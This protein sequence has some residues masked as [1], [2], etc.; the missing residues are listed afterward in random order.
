MGYFL[1]E[2]HS[3]KSFKDEILENICLSQND[4]TV[5]IVYLDELKKRNYC[6]YVIKH[7][8]RY[9]KVPV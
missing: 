6:V 8:L 9:L 2:V 3:V 5:H 7:I 1:E 4:Y